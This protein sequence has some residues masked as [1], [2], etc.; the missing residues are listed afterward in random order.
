MGLF[1]FSRYEDKFEMLKT[2]YDPD[3]NGKVD[4]DLGL[5]EAMDEFVS[6]NWNST[7]SVREY[8]SRRINSVRN[9]L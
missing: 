7:V 6:R 5:G 3:G 9:Q 8:F 1:S 4:N 2:I